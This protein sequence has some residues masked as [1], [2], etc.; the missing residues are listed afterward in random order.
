MWK[1]VYIIWLCGIINW[2]KN[3]AVFTIIEIL[4]G[5]LIKYLIIKYSHLMKIITEWIRNF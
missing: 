2:S 3:L 5:S 1:A 4:L